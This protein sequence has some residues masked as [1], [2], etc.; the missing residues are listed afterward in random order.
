MSTSGRVPIYVNSGET[1]SDFLDCDTYI[2]IIYIYI[3]MCR[4]VYYVVLYRDS[5]PLILY[6]HFGRRRVPSI[7]A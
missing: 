1:K 3:I 4:Q 7:Y 6:L 5:I 2:R